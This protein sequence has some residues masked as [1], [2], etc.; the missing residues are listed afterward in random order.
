MSQPFRGKATGIGL[1]HLRHFPPPLNSCHSTIID[2]NQSLNSN[3][4]SSTLLLNQSH[5]DTSGASL[6]PTMPRLS[7]LSKAFERPISEDEICVLNEDSCP[8]SKISSLKK[9]VTPCDFY[10]KPEN[11]LNDPRRRTFSLG[12]ASWLT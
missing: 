8:V 3:N 9:G 6:N 11:S 1:M 2:S 7:S 10:F 12:N 4:K 5:Y